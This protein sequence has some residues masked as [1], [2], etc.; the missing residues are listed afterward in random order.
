MDTKS[1]YIYTAA[2][3]DTWDSIAY[4]AYL[5]ESLASVVLQANPRMCSTVMFEGGE[6]IVVPILTQ[7]TMPKSLPPWRR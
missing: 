6:K 4:K 5:D 2:K 3:G 7:E 1:N